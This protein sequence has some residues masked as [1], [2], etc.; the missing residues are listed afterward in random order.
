[1]MSP[2]SIARCREVFVLAVLVAMVFGAGCATQAAYIPTP[3]EPLNVVITG[4]VD[5]YLVDVMYI[6]HDD[7]GI[8]TEYKEIQGQVSHSIVGERNYYRWDSYG[9]RKYGPGDQVPP[10]TE[11]EPA[12]GFEYFMDEHLDDEMSTLPETSS[13][14]RSMDG[15]EFYLNLIDLHMWDV[16]DAM[17]F[18]QSDDQVP[19]DNIISGGFLEVPGDTVE[20]DLTTQELSLGSWD[21]VS[22]NLEMTAGVIYAE[23]IGETMQDGTSYDIVFFRQE[24]ALT[25]TVVG[26]GMEMPY[27]G[28]NRFNGLMYLYK[29]G[30]LA[31]AWYREYVYG[32]VYAPMDQIVIVHN[33]RRYTITRQSAAP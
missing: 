31:R 16:Y 26:L 5:N 14:P 23:Y 24:Q 12:V 28:T 20:Y 4:P 18:R 10:Y 15:F 6:T 13:L 33:E 32:K 3:R 8:P 2:N 25:Q 11:F 22:K 7:T 30:G 29:D 1:M 27:E 9:I 21:N 19:P 17:F